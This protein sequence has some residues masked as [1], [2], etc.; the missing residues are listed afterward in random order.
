MKKEGAFLRAEITL[1]DGSKVRRSIYPGGEEVYLET[2]KM[3][4]SV[5]SFIAKRGA[6]WELHKFYW[7]NKKGEQNDE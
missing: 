7:R 6:W 1:P 2:K 4:K 3:L 5:E